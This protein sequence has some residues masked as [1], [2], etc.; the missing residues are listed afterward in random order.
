ME[1][2]SLTVSDFWTNCVYSTVGSRDT[3]AV[4]IAFAPRLWNSYAFYLF[5]FY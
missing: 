3:D 5:I 4:K 2:F 1:T